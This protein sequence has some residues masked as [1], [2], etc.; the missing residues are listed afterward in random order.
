MTRRWVFR[1][2]VEAH[3]RLASLNLP[4]LVQRVLLARGLADPDHVSHF[5][6]PRLS[7]LHHPSLM[8][9]IDAAARRLVHAVRANQAI[10][11]YGDYDV[12][13]ITAAATLYHVIRAAHPNARLT[14]YVPHRLEEGYGV[15]SDALQQLK[16][17]GV[18]LVVTVDCGITAP[19]PAAHARQIGLDLIITDHHNPPAETHT[20]PDALIVH[21]RLPGSAYPFPDL[22]G[23]AVAFKLAWRFATAWCDSERVSDNLQRTLLDMLPLAALGTIAD[24]MPLRGENRIIASFG[25]RLLK[26]TALPGLHALIEASNLMD[27]N[28][29]SEKVGFILAPRLNACGRM[30]HAAEAVHML[31]DA[32][33]DEAADIA[34]RLSQ[35]NRQRQQTERAITEH[36]ARMAEDAGM[37]GDHRRA[38]VLADPSWHPGVVGIACARLVDRF[39]RPAILLQKQPDVCK[40]SARSIDGYSIYDALCDNSDLLASFGGHDVAAGLTLATSNLDRFSDAIIDHANAR[41]PVDHLLPP[42]YIDCDAM[43]HELDLTAVKR[44]AA[45]SPFGRANRRPTL[46][47]CDATLAEPPRQIGSQGRHLDMRLRQDH[48]GRRR[49]IR[50][51][52]WRSGALASHFASG[53]KLDVAVEPKLNEWNG[54]LNIEAEI[55]DV[56]VRHP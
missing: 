21:P 12:D 5:C 13:G 56:I 18:D 33:P 1:E 41:I 34:R 23:A 53:M 22:C 51:V 20:L 43:L 52:W 19:Q 28:I 31:T 24:V 37:T 54:R 46:R 8:P 45:L 42:I 36:A 6:Q 39:G 35:L 25:L 27:A 55:K 30:G 11:I 26:Q 32:R 16:S 47:V 29:D 15:N 14:T 38:I 48:C 2:P 40:G 9:N 3:P 50:A 17:D 4:P 7:D 49:V 10:A 44:I